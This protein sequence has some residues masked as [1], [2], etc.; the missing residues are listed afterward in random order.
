MNPPDSHRGLFSPLKTTIAPPT[1]TMMEEKTKPTVHTCPTVGLSPPLPPSVSHAT[2]VSTAPATRTRL[3]RRL[4]DMRSDSTRSLTSSSEDAA[5]NKK[6]APFSYQTGAL[7]SSVSPSTVVEKELYFGLYGWIELEPMAPVV[8]STKRMP[9]SDAELVAITKAKAKARAQE[10]IKLAEKLKAAE[11]VE[12]PKS[13]ATSTPE[14]NTTTMSPTMDKTATTPRPLS[15]TKR[16]QR[17]TR[18]EPQVA[19]PM[20]ESTAFIKEYPI[21]YEHTPPQIIKKA[22]D[23]DVVG[24][25]GGKFL[26]FIGNVNFR[27]IVAEY[28]DVYA[29]IPRSEKYIVARKVWETVWKKGGRFLEVH[30]NGEQE[31]YL[32]MTRD[33]CMKKILQTLR[34]RKGWAGHE[35]GNGR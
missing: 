14:V 23:A 7:C 26:T 27:K 4:E 15:K 10:R 30:P 32:L 11:D 33:R 13:T 9:R 3:K 18:Q 12:P 17:Q 1:T 8:L 19:L 31:G 25:R 28:K 29:R 21:D 34:E 24:G 20:V 35:E 16:S 2:V 5:P 6:L 22:T